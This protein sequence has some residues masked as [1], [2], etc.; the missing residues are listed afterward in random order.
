M[1]ELEVSP[2]EGSTEEPQA[3]A[4]G[5]SANREAAKYRTKLR[6][7]ETKLEAAQARITALLRKEIEGHAA[8]ELSVG[9]D[10]FEIGGANVDDMTDPEGNVMPDA[11]DVAVDALLAKRPGLGNP[12]RPWGEVGGNHREV[13]ER[14]P[15]MQDALKFKGR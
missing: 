4:E 8:K 5:S 1:T 9:A 11:V 14:A 7:A 13:P 10:L 2:A 6:D 12:N 3:P 15:T